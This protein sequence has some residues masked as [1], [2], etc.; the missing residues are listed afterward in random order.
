[1]TLTFAKSRVD[2]KQAIAVRYSSKELPKDSALYLQRQFGTARVWKNVKKLKG[3]SGAESV[4]GV[5][6][7]QYAFR[8]LARHDGRPV[9]ASATKKLYSYGTVSIGVLCN[10]PNVIDNAGNGCPYSGSTQV[11]SNIFQY[12]ILV[13]DNSGSVYP[14]FWNLID[15][16]ATTCRSITFRFGMPQN[17]SQS[18]DTAYIETVEQTLDPQVRSVGYGGLR[19]FRAALD[20]HPWFLENSATNGNDG[21]AINATASCYTVS[22]Y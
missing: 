12:K 19:T 15:F 4:P 18:G 2:A 1:M 10:N 20:G 6:Q 13:E 17:S 11:G 7:G 21:I 14:T 5:P 16:P 9:V 22:G 3:T 8:I